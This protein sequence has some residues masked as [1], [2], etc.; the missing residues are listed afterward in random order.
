LEIGSEEWDGKGREG[1]REGR[2]CAI[3]M[4]VGRRTES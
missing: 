1:R 2:G 3:F 4:K